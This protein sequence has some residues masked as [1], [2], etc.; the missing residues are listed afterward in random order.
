HQRIGKFGPG[1]QPFAGESAA[2]A[3]QRACRKELQEF[4]PAGGVIGE[5]RHG[6]PPSNAVTRATQLFRL[7]WTRQPVH[8]THRRSPH[9]IALPLQEKE[10]RSCPVR[11][12][13]ARRSTSSTRRDAS[14]S[15]IP[16]PLVRRAPC[17]AW[18]LRRSRPPAPALPLPKDCPT[19]ASPA[20]PC[21][22]ISARS[23]RRPMCP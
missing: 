1:H 23:Q 13:S 8:P 7:A 18:D 22:R 17:K 6:E 21:S 14:S 19:A 11:P 10:P 5:R 15:P 4:A 16:G 20:P 2:S 12:K 3:E 9:T